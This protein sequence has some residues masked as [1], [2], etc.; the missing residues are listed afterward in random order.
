MHVYTCICVDA[1]DLDTA[2]LLESRLAY[3]QVHE[4]QD[5]CD[6]GCAL[7]LWAITMRCMCVCVYVCMYVCMYVCIYP[8]I[9][10]HTHT[11]T[12]MHTLRSTVWSDSE[13]DCM[14]A[15]EMGGKITAWNHPL[16]LATKRDAKTAMGQPLLSLCSL[17]DSLAVP[18]AV[19]LASRIGKFDLNV[20][21]L[22]DATET[23][24]I[25]LS[26]S[27]V[28]VYNS[29]GVPLVMYWETP[30]RFR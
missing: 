16:C 13:S 22:S 27:L 2:M 20:T 28:R 5:L 10:I 6:R 29:M 1:K 8:F 11:Y 7:S 3:K 14:F 15:V 12:Y 9:N 24:T 23:G 19:L 25:M 26:G 4:Y 17:S 30:G 18:E 21:L